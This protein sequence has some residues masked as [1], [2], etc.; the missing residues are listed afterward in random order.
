MLF[1]RVQEMM[2]GKN[3]DEIKEIANNIAKER[4]IDLSQFANQLGINIKT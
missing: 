4:G 1:Q 3:S 2:K